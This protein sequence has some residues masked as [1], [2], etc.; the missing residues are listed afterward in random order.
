MKK[1]WLLLLAI[2]AL[3]VT[4]CD[5]GGLNA[6]SMEDRC[7]R[8][9]DALNYECHYFNDL[10]YKLPNWDK[11]SCLCWNEGMETRQEVWKTRR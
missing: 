8:D 9:C 2:V 10:G 4:S 3:L 5:D 7:K 1:R 6:E 11:N